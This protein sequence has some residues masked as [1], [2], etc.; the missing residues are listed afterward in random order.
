MKKG[1]LFDFN[2]TMFFDS[3]KHKDAWDV[4]SKK[5]RGI[6]ISDE[7]MDHMHGQTNKDIIRILLGDMS[8]EESKKLSE[9]KEALYRSICKEQKDSFHLAPG[10]PQLLD[11]LKKRKIPMTI[12]SASIKANIDFFVASFHLD[13][14]FDVDNIVYDDGLHDNKIA[15]FHDGAQRIQVPIE[16]CMVIE[17]S[18]SG[19][20]FARQCHV[21]RIVA[22]TTPD[23]TE[24]YKKLPGVDKI[25]Y[26]F[27]DFDLSFFQ[28]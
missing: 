28:D 26:D 24:E 18:L 19:I 23:R 7:E 20:E 27:D 11:E 22:I 9:D 1:L 2:G 14:W 3:P 12:C 4:F 5:Y 17:D 10:L 21:A 6:P 8:D 16:H 25:I 13:T 15:M